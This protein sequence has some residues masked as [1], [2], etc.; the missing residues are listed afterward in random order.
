TLTKFLFVVIQ[1]GEGVIKIAATPLGFPDILDQLFAEIIPFFLLATGAVIT[2]E[3]L[4]QVLELLVDFVFV[5]FELCN[6]VD[7]FDIAFAK[8]VNTP[9]ASWRVEVLYNEIAI[10]DPC[11]ERVSRHPAQHAPSIDIRTRDDT[12]NRR[13][14]GTVWSEDKIQRPKTI[15]TGS[16]CVVGTFVC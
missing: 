5:G 14:S 8:G 16:R 11:I 10:V 2:V 3:C 7:R 6:L 12:G 13:F 15:Q 1:A 9:D 4:F